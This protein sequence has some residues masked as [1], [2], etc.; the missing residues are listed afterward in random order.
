VSS[1]EEQDRILGPAGFAGMRAA[2][3]PDERALYDRFL[4]A[5][6]DDDTATVDA[7]LA[8]RQQRQPA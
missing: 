7:I 8:Q 5:L 6:A 2:L 1:A 3:T 4:Q